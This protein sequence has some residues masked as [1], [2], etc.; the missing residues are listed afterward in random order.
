[1]FINQLQYQQLAIPI[2]HSAHSPQHP[3]WRPTSS[4]G[5]GC[6]WSKNHAN[7]AGKRPR[8]SMKIVGKDEEILWRYCEIL[9]NTVIILWNTW[10]CHKVYEILGNTFNILWNTICCKRLWNMKN[11]EHIHKISEKSELH[12]KVHDCMIAC[13]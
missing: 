1:M 13:S 7:F 9:G 4:P 8:T 5:I 10:K 3:K 6:R 11:F 12:P 2:P